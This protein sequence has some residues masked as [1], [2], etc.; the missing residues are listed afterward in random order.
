LLFNYYTAGGVIAANGN[1]YRVVVGGVSGTVAPS[2][3]SGTAVNGGITWEYIPVRDTNH[4][5]QD[6][7]VFEN[8]GHGIEVN[9]QVTVNFGSHVRSYNNGQLR[10]TNSAGVLLH[11]AKNCNLFKPAIFDNQDVPTQEN[12]LWII[13]GSGHKIFDANVKDNK[14][15]QIRKNES[16]V[17]ISV[18]SLTTSFISLSGPQ[19][20]GW[21]GSPDAGY[22]KDPDGFVQFAGYFYGGATNQLALML[23]AENRP[24]S[25]SNYATT[26][27]N[28]FAIAAVKSTGEVQLYTSNANHYVN[29][30]RYKSV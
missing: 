18:Y 4:T 26:A 24:K 12:G 10:S 3:T 13:G 23:P 1:I 25:T 7:E 2:H 27:N 19:L 5:I 17:N 21:I 9:D 15:N 14:L 28:S 20:N 6:A 29:T 11:R 30:I 22:Y 8:A 16:P